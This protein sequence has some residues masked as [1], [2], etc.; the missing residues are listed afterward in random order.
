MSKLLVNRTEA[1][2]QLA[3][4]GYQEGDFVYLRFF[5]PSSDPR[6]TNDPGTKLQGIY[7]N[8]IDW[9]EIETLQT[10]GRGAYLVVNGGG[11]KD[12]NVRSCFA[13]FYE[14]DNLDKELQ[15]E[16]WRS[17]GLPEP[18]LQID[19][20]GKSIHSYWVFTTPIE[21]ALW[22][23]LQTDLLEFADADRSLK[24]PSRVM[25]LAGGWHS[26]GQQSRILLNT[27]NTYSYEA[28]RSMIPQSQVQQ[29]QVTAAKTWAEHDRSF[30]LPIAESVPLEV[31]L[32]KESRRLL[33]EGVWEGGR[34]DR[35]YAVACDLIGTAAHL[36]HL[37]QQ[38]SGNA[39]TMFDDYC[40]RCTPPLDAAEIESVWKSAE[41]RSS[42]PSCSPEQIEGCI[43][44][45]QWRSVRDDAAMPTLNTANV[46]N[47]DEPESI[48][49]QRALLEELSEY[50][51]SRLDL[52]SVYPA[53]LA[54][55]LTKQA[56]ALPIAPECL[57]QVFLSVCAGIVGTRADVRIH[58]GW[59]EPCVIW[60]G[61]VGEP[62]F[63][64]SPAMKV[65]RK[66]LVSLQTKARELFEWRQEENDS[67]KRQWDAKKKEDK[68]NANPAEIPVDPK[69]RHYYL[70]DTTLD[71]A[72]SIH[73]QEES[74]TGFSL[75]YDEL[76]E[77]FDGLDQ[78]KAGKGND[79]KKLLRLWNG[80]DLKTD[81]KSEGASVFVP[82]SAI[83]LSGAI[84]T[85]VLEKQMGDSE[86]SDGM[87]GR[88]LWSAPP[89]IRSDRRSSPVDVSELLEEV[90]QKLDSMP[91]GRLFR[92]SPDAQKLF[93]EFESWVEDKREYGSMALK[94]ALAKMVGYAARIALLLHCLDIALDETPDKEIIPVETMQRS[95]F[96]CQ[97]YIQQ[98]KLLHSRTVQAEL[99]PQLLKIL[100]LAQATGSV[101]LREVQ[102][103]RLAANAGEARDFLMQIERLG[104]GKVSQQGRG[105]IIFHLSQLSRPVTDARDSWNPR[106]DKSAD[107]FTHLS[108]LS[109]EKSEPQKT[110]DLVTEVHTNR[111]R[112]EKQKTCDTVTEQ[113]QSQAQQGVECVTEDVTSRDRCDSSSKQS[114]VTVKGFGFGNGNG[115][116]KHKE[117]KQ[118]ISY[119]EFEALEDY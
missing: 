109:Q 62:G 69:M 65:V 41:K 25:R 110:A 83:S 91:E 92:L 107:D 56:L 117:K 82:K 73:A 57:H 95:L 20:G 19:T 84:Q 31:C 68:A 103:K 102:R 45:W 13:I 80:G 7:P 77:L 78:Y 34:N 38:Y 106:R 21:V 10:D 48:E 18:T 116:S 108:H 105:S 51:R 88:I 3:A 46:A 79:R 15:V 24:N 1:I 85:S 96:L 23:I 42:G 61:F 70:E 66:P 54:E 4:L 6:K 17:L 55:A 12:E 119:Q 8:E 16:L 43:K 49:D 29:A 32:S 67:K 35:G 53:A 60:T 37:G 52:H 90:Y 93:Y 59:T 104:F 28:L 27:G 33:E 99:P 118:A 26:S 97:Y 86:D 114:S 112:G 115:S 47:D 30:R 87:W 50:S 72:I 111:D 44:G 14:H 74:S 100:E 101:S 63:K 2:A 9:E 58:Q 94:N 89:Y 98:V 22:R 75:L 39:R 64:K 76:A 81:R 71:A 36:S 11:H 113:S 40:Q 5:Y